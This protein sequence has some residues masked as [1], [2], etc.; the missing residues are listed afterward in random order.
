MLALDLDSLRQQ[1]ALSQSELGLFLMI[2]V[3]YRCLAHSQRDLGRM[4]GRW[5][6]RDERRC[7]CTRMLSSVIEFGLLS[8]HFRRCYE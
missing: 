5:H 6:A 8:E 4:G 3:G 7:L 2:S 1:L